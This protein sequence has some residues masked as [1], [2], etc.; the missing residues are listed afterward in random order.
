MINSDNFVSN[1]RVLLTNVVIA[2]DSSASLS[3]FDATIDNREAGNGMGD[4]LVEVFNSIFV[5][6]SSP[7]IIR[8]LEAHNQLSQTLY[9][10]VE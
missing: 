2:A 3:P 9:Y 4:N 6:N 8:N 7:Y 1:S 10:Q 5:N